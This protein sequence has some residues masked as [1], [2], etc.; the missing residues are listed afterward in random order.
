M[1][2]A[3]WQ[4]AMGPHFHIY[5]VGSVRKEKTGP[6]C[7]LRQ[8]VAYKGQL[9]GARQ[10]VSRLHLKII[11][12]VVPGWISTSELEVGFLV[13]ERLTHQGIDSFL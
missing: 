10:E 4:G 11:L 7:A 5:S 9:G 3:S 8:A 2:N 12:Q 13:D 6:T 1:R